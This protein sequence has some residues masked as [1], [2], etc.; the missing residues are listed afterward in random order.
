MLISSSLCISF[1]FPISSSLAIPGPLPT[2][3]TFL[4]QGRWLRVKGLPVSVDA[5]GA[6]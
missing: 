2:T 4:C 6:F 3:L 5:N 1:S